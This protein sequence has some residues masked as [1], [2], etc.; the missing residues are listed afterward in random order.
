MKVHRLLTLGGLAVVAAGCGNDDN[1]STSP[2]Q[3]VAYV[4]YVNAIPDTSGVDFRFVDAIE[5]SPVFVGVNYRQYTPYQQTGTGARHVKVFVSP[6]GYRADSSQII[7]KQFLIDTTVTFEPNTYYTVL[8]AGY[9]KA[10]ATPKQRLYV[11]KDVLPAEAGGKISLRTINALFPFGNAD[12]FAT[13]EESTT[14]FDGSALEQNVPVIDPTTVGSAVTAYRTLD[15]RPNTSD[16]ITY[17]L[18][19]RKAG[20]TAPAAGDSLASLAP[21][22][23]SND[24]TFANAVA[25]TQV[26]KTVFT[27]VLLP[28]TVTCGCP[29]SRPTFAKPGILFMVDR[30]GRKP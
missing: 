30:S 18:W 10:G 24:G 11:I 8:H 5:N 13:T 14:P 15:A 16:T 3:N 6:N 22:R 28:P 19:V 20:M 7:A 29:A 2:S 1:G 9:A 17:K 27:Q 23:V 21:A 26:D 4:R 25:G 12:A